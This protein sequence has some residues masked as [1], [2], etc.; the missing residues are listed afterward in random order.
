MNKQYTITWYVI[1]HLMNF[2][3][4]ILTLYAVSNGIEEANPV[5]AW[6]LS[7]SPALFLSVKFFVFGC[8]VHFVALKRPA[9]LMY[10]G[11]LFM[12]VL[13]WHVSFWLFGLGH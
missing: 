12:T 7:I 9:L 11:L 10:V 4:A 8:A 3:D 13:C 1:S 2:C 5:M 6:A